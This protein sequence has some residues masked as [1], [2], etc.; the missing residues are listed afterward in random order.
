MF[1]WCSNKVNVE[2]LVYFLTIFI[3]RMKQLLD[4]KFCIKSPICKFDKKVIVTSRKIT[5]TQYVD[6]SHTN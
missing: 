4:I 2:L 6:Y 3:N 5:V 1:K